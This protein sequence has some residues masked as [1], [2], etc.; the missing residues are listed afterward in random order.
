MASSSMVKPP[1]PKSTVPV[2]PVPRS[3][4]LLPSASN[5]AATAAVAQGVTPQTNHGRPPPP[6]LPAGIPKPRPPPPPLPPWSKP[7][8][9]PLPPNGGHTAIAAN[10]TNSSSS[11]TAAMGINTPFA[12]RKRPLESSTCVKSSTGIQPSLPPPKHS[13]SVSNCRRVSLK[14]PVVMRDVTVFQ[15][16]HQVGE[17]TYGYVVK[18][19]DGVLLAPPAFDLHY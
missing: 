12:S 18:G 3:K 13:N 11:T 8:P 14:A 15:K 6:P 2:P 4:P 1:P 17:G 16:R 19:E 9:P 5:S 10:A 7:R